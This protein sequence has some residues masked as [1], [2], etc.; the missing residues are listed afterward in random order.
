MKQFIV[1]I[2]VSLLFGCSVSKNSKKGLGDTRTKRLEFYNESTYL[3]SEQA[4]DKSYAFSPSNPVKVGGVKESSGPLNERRFLNALLSPDG[5][6]VKFFRA[7]SCCMFSTPNGLFGD[8]GLLDMYRIYWD[9]SKD[10]LDIYINMYDKGDLKIP[11]G[12]KARG[13]Q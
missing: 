13:Q 1:I 9:G 6:P 3:L 8:S 2:S 4:L 12:L 10:T 11:M 5:K 7:G